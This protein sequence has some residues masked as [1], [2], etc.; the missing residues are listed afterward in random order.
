MDI[1]SDER[2]L[3][4]LENTFIFSQMSRRELTDILDGS[5]CFVQKFDKGSIIYDGCHFSRS[6]GIF[7]EGS[8]TVTKDTLDGRG[9]SISR[10]K[11]GDIFGAAAIFN[12]SSTYATVITALSDCRI[13]FM[14]QDFILDAMKKNFKLAE[15]YIRY[16]SGRI[17]FLNSKIA[18]LT[19]GSTEER[20]AC[21]IM[22][23][24]GESGSGEINISMTEL[25]SSLN[26]GR[27][28]LYR[29]FDALEQSGAVSREGKKVLI[30]DETK[31]KNF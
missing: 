18:E 1:I 16:L 19:A 23:L 22:K 30:L 14:P 10:L 15:N 17:L 13:F 31:L 9:L 25:A 24:S 12:K 28:S 6:L 29:A 7:L 5:P 11:T 21:Y 8:A 20:L 27:A 2:Q 26:I 4:I 3:E